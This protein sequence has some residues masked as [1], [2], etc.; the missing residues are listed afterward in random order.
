MDTCLFQFYR[1]YQTWLGWSLDGEEAG[2][3]RPGYA[4]DGRRSGR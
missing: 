1:R 2:N 3:V 4:S